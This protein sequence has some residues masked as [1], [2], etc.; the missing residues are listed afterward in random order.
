MVQQLLI[1]KPMQETGGWA[2]TQILV[3]LTIMLQLFLIYIKIYSSSIQ[4]LAQVIFLHSHQQ[5]PIIQ[6]GLI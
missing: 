5:V 4:A 6:G 3:Q 1:H 2:L